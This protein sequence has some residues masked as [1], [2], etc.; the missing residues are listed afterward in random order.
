MALAMSVER[1]QQLPSTSQLPSGAAPSLQWQAGPS[2]SAA[3][4]AAASS[5]GKYKAANLQEAKSAAAMTDLSKAAGESSEI[6]QGRYP[7][8]GQVGC[9]TCCVIC[10]LGFP[11]AGHNCKGRGRSPSCCCSPD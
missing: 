11:G 2:R 5:A 4:A 8:H 9:G 10:K 6:S 3:A 7:A 1:A